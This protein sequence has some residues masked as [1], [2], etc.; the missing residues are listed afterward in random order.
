MLP[1]VKYVLHGIFMIEKC[2]AVLIIE[3]ISI[4]NNKKIGE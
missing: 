3:G 1:T 4:I 2:Y